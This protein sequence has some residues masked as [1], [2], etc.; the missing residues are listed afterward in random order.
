MF[1]IGKRKGDKC[2]RE[3]PDITGPSPSRTTWIIFFRTKKKKKRG[4]QA[5]KKKKKN[6]VICY[7]EVNRFTGSCAYG[8]WLSWRHFQ[9]RIDQLTNNKT[10]SHISSREFP[11]FPGDRWETKTGNLKHNK[12]KNKNK[13]KKKLSSLFPCRGDGTEKVISIHVQ[14]STFSHL[15]FPSVC[16]YYITNAKRY[17]GDS[18]ALISWGLITR[19]LSNQKLLKQNKRCGGETFWRRVASS[20]SVG[21]KKP[22][23]SSKGGPTHHTSHVA[24]AGLSPSYMVTLLYTMGEDSLQYQRQ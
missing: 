11:S 14:V 21:E 23:L 6:V 24:T 12:T 17:E 5:K 8:R 20:P 1:S 10:K 22:T 7:F 15:V 16:V 3:P 19:K 9:G 18:S 2:D 4:S 13:T